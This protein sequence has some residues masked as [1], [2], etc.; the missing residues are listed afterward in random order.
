MKENIT[1]LGLVRNYSIVNIILGTKCSL[2]KCNWEE[3]SYEVI[4][5][6]IKIM[7]TVKSITK[8]GKMKSN[9]KL[10]LRDEEYKI[11]SLIF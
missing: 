8:N 2:E 10:I 3:Q 9:I 7:E 1:L 4:A 6:F 5:T 11:V